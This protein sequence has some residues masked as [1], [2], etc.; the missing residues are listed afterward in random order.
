MKF[1]YEKDTI[2]FSLSDLLES[3]TGDQK[4]EL[5]ERLAC[6]NEI[7]EHVV[8]QIATGYTENCS[9]GSRG[10]GCEIEPHTPLDKARRKLA[11]SAGD[12][13]KAELKSAL[14]SLQNQK[15]WHDHY[16]DWAFEMYHAWGKQ[17]Q[18]PHHESPKA[19]AWDEYEVIKRTK[20][21]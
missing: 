10:C 6:E 17:A 16:R 2:S 13:A 8:S 12:V 18:C 9:S 3:L 7:I 5:V 11:E 14:N 21:S 19:G 15:A 20:P 4:K 1:N